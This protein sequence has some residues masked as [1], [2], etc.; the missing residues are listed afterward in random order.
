MTAFTDLL[1]DL[2][3]VLGPDHPRVLTSRRNLGFFHGKAGAPATAV[4][5]LTEVLKDQV[6]LL[7]PDHRDTEVTRTYLAEWRAA[8]NGPP[9]S[10]S[11]R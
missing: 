5:I 4:T 9:S 8:L 2:E 3:R 1:R 7:G 10:T 6:R 11:E